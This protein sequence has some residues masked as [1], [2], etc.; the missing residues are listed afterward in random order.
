MFQLGADGMKSCSVV[1]FHLLQSELRLWVTFLPGLY[2]CLC[3]LEF[4]ALVVLP[5]S[6]LGCPDVT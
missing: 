3:Y 1:I 5:L 6:A 4:D 2:D